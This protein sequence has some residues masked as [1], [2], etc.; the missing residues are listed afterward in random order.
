MADAK[1]TDLPEISVP[2]VTD[3]LYGVSDP[4]GTPTSAKLSI[5]RLL[6]ILATC[7]G[8]LT[9]ETGVPVSTSDRTSQSTIYFTPY[10]GSIIA[11]YDGTRWQGYKFSEVSLALSGLTSSKPYDVFLYNNSGTLTLELSAAWSSDTA[12]TDALVLQDSVYVKSGATTR[13]WL[14]TIYTTATTTTE[15]SASNRYVWNAYN[16]VKRELLKTDA[17][18]SWTYGTATWRSANG[19]TAN[20]VSVVVGSTE[21]SLELRVHGIKNG[22]GNSAQVGIAEDG[23]STPHTNCLGRYV[24]NASA[25][26]SGVSSLNIRPGLGRH[27]YQWVEKANDAASVT[28]FGTAS[29][30]H[31]KAGMTGWVDA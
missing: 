29:G 13:R 9:T 15:D 24:S 23:T 25:V 7:N 17:T 21:S 8:R 3:L 18:T 11:L 2:L 30:D 28:F 1:V 10:N 26:A 19:S 16:R 6:G 4:A 12:R 5:S 27:F 31:Y 20:R 14:G 22:G